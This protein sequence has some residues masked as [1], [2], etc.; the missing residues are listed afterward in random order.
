[1]IPAGT[2]SVRPGSVASPP[3]SDP[4]V[5]RALFWLGLFF[6]AAAAIAYGATVQDGIAIPRDGAGLVVGRDFLN[7]WMYGR[8][9]LPDPATGTTSPPIR[10]R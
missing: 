10:T 7:T 3:A 1:M 6:L 2:L 5:L 4:D 9:A 8:A